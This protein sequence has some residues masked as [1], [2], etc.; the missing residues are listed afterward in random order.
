MESVEVERRCTENSPQMT[1]K[2]RSTYK[3]LEWLGGSS[4]VPLSRRPTRPN[5]F[6]AQTAAKPRVLGDWSGVRKGPFASRAQPNIDT[7]RP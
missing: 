6:R 4:P 5:Q 3:N 1:V 7:L 2:T